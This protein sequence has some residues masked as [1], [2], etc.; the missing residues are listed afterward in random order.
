[1]NSVVTLAEFCE[2][3][4]LPA[5]VVP[6]LVEVLQER[7]LVE[8]ARHESRM[9]RCAASPSQERLP[10]RDAEGDFGVVEASIPKTLFYNLLARENF[11]WEGLTSDEGL[12]DI[13]KD[14][15]QCRVK[16]VSGKTVVGWRGPQR[17]VVKK[18]EDKAV[19]RA[20]QPHSK[21]LRDGEHTDT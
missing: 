6:Q 4:G 20:S 8:L 11:G 12:R 19:A 17:K 13:L 18:Y 14:N 21:T 9:K 10:V 1:M 7:E 2:S 15:P 5:T 3:S 16:T